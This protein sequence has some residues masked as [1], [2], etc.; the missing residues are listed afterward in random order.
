M[1]SSEVKLYPIPEFRSR[2]HLTEQMDEPCSRDEMRA[3]L[4]DIARLNRWFRAH[5]PL[6]RWLDGFAIS[7]LPRPLRILDV[8]CGYGDGLRRIKR[9]AQSRNLL[10]ELV[11]LDINPDAVAVAAEATP[12]ASGI[13]WIAANV[14]EFAPQDPVHLVVSS[15]FTHHLNEPQIVRF[16]QW[17]EHTAILGWFI[18]DLSRAAIPYH[19]IRIFAR[20]ARLH[21]FVQNDAAAS[22]ARSFVTH[23]WQRLCAAANLEERDFTI[24]PHKPARLCVGRRKLP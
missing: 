19:F 6:L 7:Q 18:N 4:R 10:V 9:W 21:P 2:A 3:C 15:Q 24:Q 8:G 14:L 12:P 23:D 5:I 16:L 11:G 20:I 22:I 17:M 13:R 1:S